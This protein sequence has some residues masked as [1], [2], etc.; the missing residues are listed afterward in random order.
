LNPQRRSFAENNLS[1]VI[2]AGPI[3]VRKEVCMPGWSPGMAVDEVKRPVPC[4]KGSV[5][6][7]AGLAA[8]SRWRWTIV[9]VRQFS[10]I[11]MS[12]IHPPAGILCGRARVPG[13]DPF[14]A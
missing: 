3:N 6:M 2:G 11:A 5:Q 14:R 10:L 12:R 4:A 8:R 1:L 7:D 9:V 13:F